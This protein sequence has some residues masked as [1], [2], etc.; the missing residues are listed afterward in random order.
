MALGDYI[1]SEMIALNLKHVSGALAA[2]LGFSLV[3]W[4]SEK[5]M[6]SGYV[7]TLIHWADNIVVASCIIYLTVVILWELGR[8]LTRLGK[9]R[10][11]GSPSILAA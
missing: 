3:T 7:L 5:L 11:N 1:D 10:G 4:V 9:G 8:R 2:I 6:N